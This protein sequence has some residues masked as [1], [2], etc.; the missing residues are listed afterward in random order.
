MSLVIEVNGDPYGNFISGEVEI[1]LDVLCNTFNFVI[2]RSRLQPLPFRVGDPCKIRVNGQ[3]VLTGTIELMTVSFAEETHTIELAG[4]DNTSDI[5]DSSIDELSDI[6]EGPT[7][8]SIIEQVIA[9]IGSSLKVVQG[10][11]VQKFNPIN[12]IASPEPGDNAFD[13]IEGLARQRQVL[14]TSNGEGNIVITQGVADL[15]QNARVQNLI[16]AVGNNVKSATVSYDNTGRY[17]LYRLTSQGNPS[18]LASTG[19]TD[20]DSII[21]RGGGA[22]DDEVK[23]GRQLVLSAES[24]FSDDDSFD[25][26]KWEANIRRAR[27]R[28][29]TVNFKGYTIDGSL[30]GSNIWIINK[31]VPISDD[32]AGIFGKMLIN[33]VV[34]SVDDNSG[35]ISKI[36]FVEPDSYTLALEEPVS[37]EGFI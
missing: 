19:E 33:S 13:F 25:R 5:L 31:L 21:S 4:R 27:G 12:D 32:F 34:F 10:T 9:H 3:L 8:K 17:N 6:E 1:R 26:A 22:L 37:G 30:E 2:S 15:L 36:T 23:A 35:S 24:S 11:E 16:G 18:A 29:Y 28:L 14:L 7:L 20:L